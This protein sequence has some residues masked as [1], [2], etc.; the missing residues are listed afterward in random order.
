MDLIIFAGGDGKLAS[1]GTVMDVE[2]SIE[3]GKL[4]IRDTN[5][6]TVKLNRGKTWIG[7]ISSNNGGYVKIK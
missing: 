4:S 3:K 7:W 2:W 1:Q 6:N 5:G